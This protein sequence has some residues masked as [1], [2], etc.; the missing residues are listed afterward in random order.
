MDDKERE[1]CFFFLL[2]FLFYLTR[3][4][5]FTRRC[6]VIV[7]RLCD[8]FVHLSLIRVDALSVLGT[9]FLQIVSAGDAILYYI[10][11]VL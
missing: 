5:L 2:L 7:C 9:I 8:S 10:L 11:K 6:F 1:K 3:Q 4:W